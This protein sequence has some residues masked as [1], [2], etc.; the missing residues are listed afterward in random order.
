[1]AR[2][3]QL[4]VNEL[5]STGQ[6]IVTVG[7][8][9]KEGVTTAIKN[10]Y[11]VTERGTDTVHKTVFT[12]TDT[13]LTVLDTGTGVGVKIYTFPVGR[14]LPLGAAGSIA[15]TTT[16]VLASTLNASSTMAWGLG[17][18]TQA[19]NTTLA[20]TEQDFLQTTAITSSATIN[21]AGAAAAGVGLAVV[22]PF[23]GVST[24]T[25][26]FLNLAVA[27]ATDIDADATVTVT[28]SANV[29]WMNLV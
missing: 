29:Y 27:T 23:A 28:G 2:Y 21:V 13:P 1:M 14:I 11:K 12:F 5:T 10:A 22:T 8:G 6:S 18:V 16:S 4:S 24:P 15:L 26:L 17:S 9:A 25:A 20:T 7:V 3:E 19:G